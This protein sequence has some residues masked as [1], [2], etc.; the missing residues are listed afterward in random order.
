M[1]RGQPQK[2]NRCPVC[3]RKR[4]SYESEKGFTKPCYDCHKKIVQELCGLGISKMTANAM[5]STGR[6]LKWEDFA[7][8][9]SQS[10]IGVRSIGKVGRT[11]IAAALAFHQQEQGIEKYNQRVLARREDNQIVAEI[12]GL[13]TLASLAK[14]DCS[15]GSLEWKKQRHDEYHRLRGEIHKKVAALVEEMASLRAK[16]GR[17]AADTE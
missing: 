17:V 5:S 6:L 10:W 8:F 15:I 1:T 9:D 2:T 13:V 14:A 7:N 16:L 11:Q 3:G 4:T 12:D